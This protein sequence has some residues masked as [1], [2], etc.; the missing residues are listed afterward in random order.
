MRLLVDAVEA[1][2]GGERHE[3]MPVEL[4]VRDAEHQVDRPG[5]EGGEAHPRL[6]RER[7]V[8]VGHERGAALIA[9]GDE[10]DRGI[11]EGV[12]RVQVL[13]ARKPEDHLDAFL[14]EASDDRARDGPGGVPHVGQRIGRLPGGPWTSSGRHR[15]VSHRGGT[16]PRPCRA[17]LAERRSPMRV[18]LTA[19]L[20]AGAGIVALMTLLDGPGPQPPTNA[21]RRERHR[22]S[23]RRSPLRGL[24][25]ARERPAL[26]ASSIAL[27]GGFVCIAFAKFM[28]GPLGF[29]EVNQNRAIETAL[30][31][32]SLAPGRGVLGGWRC[33]RSMR[34]SCWLIVTWFQR[35][36]PVAG[37]WRSLTPGVI[38]VALVAGTGFLA[39]AIVLGV[40]PA[41]LPRVRLHVVDRPWP[42][43]CR[44]WRRRLRDHGLRIGGRRRSSDG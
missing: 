40:E 44:S 36:L 43:R 19:F 2:L 17:R 39:G 3:R 13:F 5:T 6:A 7:P 31:T 1:R 41:P 12:D 4:G 18:F 20:A 8:G 10:P 32:R 25:R 11:G 26:L 33:S 29:Y 23:E 22:R 28:F 37:R 34:R 30:P 21:V 42:S 16:R 35:R 15:I 38:A 27:A 9:R 24:R 14:L